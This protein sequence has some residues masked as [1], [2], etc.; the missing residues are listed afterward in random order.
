MFLTRFITLLIIALSSLMQCIDSLWF[1]SRIRIPFLHG[2]REKSRDA[3]ALNV[4]LENMGNTCYLNSIIQSL[5]YTDSLRDMILSSSYKSK[6]TG[7]YIQTLFK[8]MSN[9]H[10][11]SMSDICQSLDIDLSIQEDAQEF[12]LKLLNNI[13]DSISG[14][15]SSSSNSSNVTSSASPK[16]SSLFLLETENVIKC[17]NIDY[18]KHRNSKFLSLS[19][20]VLNHPTM[21]ES[22]DRYFS[23]E[24][25]NGSCQYKAGEHGYQ[26]AIKDMRIS[27][28]PTNIC[29]HLK[30]FVYDHND[31]DIKKIDSYFEFPN[32]VDL[33]KYCYE[34]S[35]STGNTYKLNAVVIH[36]GRGN[37]GHYTCYANVNRD[38]GKQQMWKYFNDHEVSD[39]TEQQVLTSAYGDRDRTGSNSSNSILQSI[40]GSKSAYLLL[41]TKI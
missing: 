31:S 38:I 1:L 40:R 19:I 2:R 37:S 30:R 11:S 9:N 33:S 13:D 14:S 18:T 16:S 4:G 25:Y 7:Y 39:A 27:K 23:S 36:E 34:N 22:L 29:F 6:S 10:M 26:D 21:I 24:S 41:Y 20:D 28:L 15:D 35:S 3:T 32:V 8:H 12:F 5:Y 17:L